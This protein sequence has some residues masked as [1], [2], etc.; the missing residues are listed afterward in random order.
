M[1]K[2]YYEFTI[3]RDAL[4]RSVV[5]K[6]DDITSNQFYTILKPQRTITMNINTS[7]TSLPQLE[8]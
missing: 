5:I 8:T 4:C 1:L 2:A 7:H 6:F 3:I